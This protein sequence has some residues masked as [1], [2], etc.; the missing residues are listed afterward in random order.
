[1]N[2]MKVPARSSIAV[3]I[4]SNTLQLPL[5]SHYPLS[6][7][8]FIQNIY[9][10][11]CV[12]PMLTQNVHQYNTEYS[13]TPHI[14]ILSTLSKSRKGSHIFM[15]TKF[16]DF[17]L[18]NFIDSRLTLTIGQAIRGRYDTTS[19]SVILYSNAITR[20]PVQATK[21]KLL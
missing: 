4:I 17:S 1:M 13:T 10:E 19:Y 8:L 14:C 3:S 12:S 9:F 2:M 5:T 16:P 6:R 20:S 18:I 15:K 21:F 7:I 11:Q